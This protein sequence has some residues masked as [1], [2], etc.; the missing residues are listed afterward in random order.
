MDQSRDH[1]RDSEWS[2]NNENPHASKRGRWNWGCVFRE[3]WI[4]E[5]TL[6]LEKNK[7]SNQW[8]KRLLWKNRKWLQMT[9]TP[10]ESKGSKDQQSVS[11]EACPSIRP[12]DLDSIPGTHTVERT[13]SRKLSSDR[14]TSTTYFTQVHVH[15]HTWMHAY[16]HLLLCK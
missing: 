15:T 13:D 2:L 1:K 16:I 8:P 10:K 9:D 3:V 14:H 12:E 6:L 5:Q 11:K 7:V 4:S